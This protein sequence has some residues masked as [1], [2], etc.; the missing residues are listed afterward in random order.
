MGRDLSYDADVAMSEAFAAAERVIVLLDRYAGDNGTDADA[1]EGWAERLRQMAA[2]IYATLGVPLARLPSG[3][4]VP[5]R[6]P[7]MGAKL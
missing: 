4:L 6:D 5:A 3:G 2:E 7:K 1:I